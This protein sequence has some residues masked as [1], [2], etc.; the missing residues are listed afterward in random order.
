[1]KGNGL[2]E[3][4]RNINREEALH[5]IPGRGNVPDHGT[6]NHGE[7]FKS[8]RLATMFLGFGELAVARR[9]CGHRGKEKEIKVPECE[10][11]S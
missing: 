2:S 6:E 3:Y 7:K 9:S 1:M 10:L 8:V 5:V 11:C 4:R